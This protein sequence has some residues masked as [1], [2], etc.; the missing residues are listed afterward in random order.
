MSFLPQRIREWMARLPG[1]ATV[2]SR[3]VPTWQAGRPLPTPDD[4]AKLAED[5]YRKNI[6]VAAC[7]WEIATSASEPVA[8]VE[9]TLPD[10]TRQL[11]KSTHPLLRLL[12]QP[13][14][15]MSWYEL[16]E[17]LHVH[18]QISGNWYVHKVRALTSVGTPGGAVVQLWPLRPDRVRIVP[19]ASGGIE[20]YT[21]SMSGAQ[22]QDLRPEDVMHCPLHPD[23]LE[24]FYGLS[25]IAA[26][27]RAVDMD[28]QGMD[29]LRAFFLNAGAPAGLLK[30]KKK[31]VDPAERSRVKLQWQS[32]HSGERGWHTVS[33]LDA[34]AEYQEI[35]SRPEK[36][37]MNTI[38]DETEAR[39]CAAF[40]VPPILIGMVIG[41]NRST[42][43]NYREA[44]VSL[45][46]ETLSPLYV[47]TAAKLTT[48]LA[49]EFGDDLVIGFDLSRVHALQEQTDGRRKW[50]A[51]GWR[52][53]L[54]TFNEARGIA[55]MPPVDGAEGTKFRPQ[56]SVTEAALSG[57]RFARARRRALHA[58]G[59]LT[60][61][62]K[63]A[64]AE[65]TR[66]LRR[67]FRDQGA[68][69]AAHLRAGEGE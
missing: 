28:N 7:I 44:R 67:H 22:P 49:V 50:A 14:P 15:T 23:P 64:K 34:D 46:D 20:K 3:I 29:Y 32:E 58:H 6:V 2:I 35:G 4:Y 60:P 42:Y 61:E 43:S 33:V 5:G 41:L 31:I 21:Y 10:G 59:R 66:V 9:R 52:S 37:R 17:I 48:G 63:R 27:A 16:M 8:I 40:G 68:A 13:N 62:Q 26:V 1:V 55:G 51:E 36:L 65:M 24:D 47:R 57:F 39:I 53:G 38:F 18:Q 11:V 25:P 56:P 19:N 54:L 12:A 45:W 30:F 69:L